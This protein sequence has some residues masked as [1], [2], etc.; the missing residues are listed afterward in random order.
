MEFVVPFLAAIVELGP[1]IQPM[2]VGARS[3]ATEM[4]V[5]RAQRLEDLD[6]IVLL[7]ALV[8]LVTVLLDHSVKLRFCNSGH[9]ALSIELFWKRFFLCN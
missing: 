6:V 1:A 8:A 9:L 4:L 7:V 5:D 2:V 3:L